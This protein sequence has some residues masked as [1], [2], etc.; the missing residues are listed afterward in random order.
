M[1][2]DAV[3]FGERHG[4]QEHRVDDGEDRRVR[5][6]AERDSTHNGRREPRARAKQPQSLAKIG[7]YPLHADAS[8]HLKRGASSVSTRLAA[9]AAIPTAGNALIS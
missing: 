3:G 7:E 8:V 1:L 5:P 9:C 2:D 4:L 6:D